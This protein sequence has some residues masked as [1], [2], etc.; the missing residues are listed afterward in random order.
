MVRP[1]RDRTGHNRGS[2]AIENET[3]P[4]IRPA[5]RQDN[6]NTHKGEDKDRKKER[7]SRTRHVMA[8]VDIAD[9]KQAC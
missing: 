5:A 3:P 9:L 8:R 2:Q 6:S 4:G 1:G 7:A